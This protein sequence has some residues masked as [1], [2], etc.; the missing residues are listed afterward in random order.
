MRDA[1]RR[2]APIG[3]KRHS[4]ETSAKRSCGMTAHDSC[5]SGTNK[6][7][8]RYDLAVIGAGSAGFSAAITAAELG[9]S[10]ALI[11]HGIIGGTCVNIGCVPSKNLIRAMES[12]H[13]PNTAAHF[14][15]IQVEGRVQD[16]RAMVRQ[17]NELV[18]TL[19]QAK[20]ID[21]LPSYNTIGYLEG[22]ARLTRDGLALN[23]NL[24]HAGKVIIAT[25]ASPSLPPISG[26]T[27]VPYLTS[28]T[29]LEIER[30]PKSLLIIGGGYIGCELGQM[31]ARA[32]V[33]VMIVDIVPILSAD[34]PEISKA[35]AG[36]FREEEITVRE[37]VQTQAIRRTGGGIALDI[38][39]P[40]GE[41]TLEAEQ[42][43]V[44]TGRR[45][46][47]MD[48]GLDEVGIDLLPNG[49]IKVDDRMR[50]TKSGFYA[51]GDVT[52]R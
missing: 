21:L 29:A 43:L 49:G 23:G 42:V 30:L 15:G 27:D 46:N 6:P 2:G 26:M 52:G 45:P 33:A 20:Y 48:L 14:A 31:F 13:Q 7:N 51:A 16:W 50:T 8:G 25:G 39:T 18:T 4:I 28:T 9:A 24:I 19:R 44:T 11:G 3:H 32:G 38:S 22:R 34:E 47:T 12:L 17:K 1:R 41:E 40:G 37:R 35:L 5:I 10:V 36:Y